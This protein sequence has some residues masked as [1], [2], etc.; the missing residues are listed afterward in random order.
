LLHLRP[1]SSKAKAGDAVWPY[2]RSV[3]RR[4]GPEEN[5]DLSP[6]MKPSLRSHFLNCEDLDDEEDEDEGDEGDEG[7]GGD[8]GEGERGRGKRRPKLNTRK[9]LL[10]FFFQTRT[11]GSRR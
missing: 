1:F 6:K 11:M 9:F 3:L 7:D 4:N 5:R 2:E 8:G 10:E